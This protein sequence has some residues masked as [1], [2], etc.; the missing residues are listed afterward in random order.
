MAASRPISGRLGGTEGYTPW[1]YGLWRSLVARFVRD[2]EAPGSS[3]GSPTRHPSIP[4]PESWCCTFSGQ[5]TAEGSRCGRIEGRRARREPAGSARSGG[6]LVASRRRDRGHR[7]RRGV[8][9]PGR[10]HDRAEHGERRGR[11]APATSNQPSGRTSSG[12]RTEADQTE[13]QWILAAQLPNGAIASHTDRTFVN[14]YLAGYAALGLG[15]RDADVGRPPV[16]GGGM[17]LR[18]VVRRRRWTRTATSPTTRSRRRAGVDRHPDSTDA[19][20][21]DVP[22]RGRRDLHGR[23]RTPARLRALA[24]KVALAV[25]RD[26]VD[27]ARR[28]AHRREARLD[29]RVPDERGRGLRRA[30]VPRVASRASSATAPGPQRGHRGRA[31]SRPVSQRL[32][33]PTT[34]ALD[35]AVHPTVPTSRRTGPS[36]IRTR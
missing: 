36:C 12:V 27:A 34:G 15:D 16:R 24:P 33:N 26:P 20:L 6:R 4:T 30:C 11:R 18:R 3:P 13:A 5:S 28:R 32:W 2:E 35:W 1:P 31:R 7:H 23:R 9:D 10:D 25:G 14:P 17:A 8:T 19:L 21:G 29:G 22:R